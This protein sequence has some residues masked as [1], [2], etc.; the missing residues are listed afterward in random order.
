MKIQ[1]MSDL[2]FEFH[3]D[4]GREFVKSLQPEGV[5]V[6]VLAGDITVGKRIGAA[7]DLLCKRYKDSK[8]LY[9][10][11]N[12]EHYHSSNKVVFDTISKAEQKYSGQLYHLDCNSVTIDGIKFHGSPMW[13]PDLG[14]AWHLKKLM[15]DFI[16]IPDF[17]S[18]V[19][20]ANQDFLDYFDKEV[21]P[22]D[23]VITHHLP[24]YKSV[25]PFFA[26]SALNSFFVC[27]MDK[28]I[29][30]KKPSYWFHGHTHSSCD[31]ASH[32][33]KIL[34]NPFGYVGHSTNIRFNPNL[35]LYI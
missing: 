16:V 33:T 5:D 4:E 12:H 7:M 8:V 26:N 28:A 25:P 24:T 35:F 34:C 32:N 30:K 1:L 10:R 20:Q 13:F 18:W 9:V 17:E 31:Y 14:T 2:H 6:L 11:G 27:D 23:I 21:S 29:A 15:S 22:G 19:Y 3:H